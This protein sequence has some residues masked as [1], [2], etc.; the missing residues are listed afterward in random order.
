MFSSKGNGN[1]VDEKLFMLIRTREFAVRLEFN[2]LG[3]KLTA[4]ASHSQ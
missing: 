3:V 4:S 2:M 1:R